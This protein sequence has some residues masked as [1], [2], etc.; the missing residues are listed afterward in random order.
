MK[1]KTDVID[2]VVAVASL[3]DLDSTIVTTTTGDDVRLLHTRGFRDKTSPETKLIY[4]YTTHV[5]YLINMGTNECTKQ[6]MSDSQESMKVTFKN[7]NVVLAIDD[8]L[9]Q[10]LLKDSTDFILITRWVTQV[11]KTIIIL[12]IILLK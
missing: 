10:K 3:D 7:N 4:D 9:I 8:I 6:R 1:T 11:T 2:L 12:L 5:K